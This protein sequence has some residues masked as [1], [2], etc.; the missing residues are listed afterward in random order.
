M[1]KCDVVNIFYDQN[2][3]KYEK[4]FKLFEDT[5]EELKDE[6]DLIREEDGDTV[7]V[8][9]RKTKLQIIKE[10]LEENRNE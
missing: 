3:V 7:I 2:Q 9:P 4:G 1:E 10:I 6:L 8:R 5:Y